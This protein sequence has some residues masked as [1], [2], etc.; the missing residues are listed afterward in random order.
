[1]R[2][3]NVFFYFEFLWH[4]TFLA[5]S[6]YEL[7]ASSQKWIILHLLYNCKPFI[8]NWDHIK[9]MN[10]KIKKF[11]TSKTCFINR[12]LILN[13]AENYMEYNRVSKSILYASIYRKRNKS[14]SKTLMK[15]SQNYILISLIYKLFE[16]W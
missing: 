8:L 1:M 10:R 13:S 11:W 16:I 5:N 15:L 4:D 2:L 6:F 12:L 14:L 9:T 3:I 7:N